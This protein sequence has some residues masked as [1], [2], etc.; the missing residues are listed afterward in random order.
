MKNYLVGYTLYGTQYETVVRTATSGAAIF[1][2][3]NMFP[4]A[5]NI[6]IVSEE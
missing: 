4:N 3:E 5:T 2:I 1:W 6:S